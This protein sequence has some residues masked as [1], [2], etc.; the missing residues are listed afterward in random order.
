MKRTPAPAT[1]TAQFYTAAELAA[2]WKVSRAWVHHLYQ[3]GRLRGVLIGRMPGCDRGGVLRFRA[4]DVVAFL[5]EAG[6]PPARRQNGAGS[7]G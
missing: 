4:E 2:S 7:A 5:G 6:T 1:T 3:S